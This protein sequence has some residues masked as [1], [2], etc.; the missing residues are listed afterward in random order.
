[1]LVAATRAPPGALQQ[2]HAA[3][4]APGGGDDLA[5]TPI[6]LQILLAGKSHHHPLQL[7]PESRG[8]SAQS[9]CGLSCKPPGA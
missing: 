3:A 1:M 8:V 5:R 2:T 4:S 9:H 7:R 6:R